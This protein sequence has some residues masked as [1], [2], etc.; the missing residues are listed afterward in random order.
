MIDIVT[1]IFFSRYTPAKKVLC[2]VPVN[3][4]QNWVSEFNRW[5]PQN[6]KDV[7]VEN[8]KTNTNPFKFKTNLKILRKKKIEL[9]KKLS[10][11]TNGKKNLNKQGKNGKSIRVSDSKIVKQLLNQMVGQVDQTIQYED[12]V[13][14]EA[15]LYS[16]NQKN[17]AVNDLIY[18]RIGDQYFEVSN[19]GAG[20]TN[21]NNFSAGFVDPT[22]II[23]DGKGSW[24]NFN[25][26]R[27]LD[28]Q[29]TM[30]SI[31]NQEPFNP[32]ASDHFVKTI[33]QSQHNF[34]IQQGL[35]SGNNL[36]NFCYTQYGYQLPTTNFN[37][38]IQHPVIEKPVIESKEQEDAVKNVVLELVN[39]VSKNVE[40]EERIPST[41]G[42]LT[43]YRSFQLFMIEA[44]KS[45]SERA[46]IIGCY[47]K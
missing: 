17:E 25:E 37:Y 11:K 28:E 4:I 47:L 10:H 45:Q 30:H 33:D 12:I 27:N 36:E 21:Q 38:K 6:P 1:F 9:A 32:I 39:Q 5:L 15:L 18:P 44:Q 41:E 24:N 22:A 40:N 8:D 31:R 16:L 20:M 19:S 42:T 26:Y 34:E 46:R 3:T 13:Q 2:V 29:K 43:N 14:Q 7:V 35:S 23:Y